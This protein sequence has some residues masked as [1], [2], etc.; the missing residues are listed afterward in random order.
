VVREEVLVGGDDGLPGL[1]RGKDERPRGLVAS[2][3]LDHDVD[4]WIGDD[5]CRSIG[6]E[7]ARQPPVARRV[8]VPNRDRGDHESVAERRQAAHDGRP[9]SACAEQ[10][11]AQRRRLHGASM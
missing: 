5:V 3:Q 4:A 6:Q 2:E 8:D 7:V 9:H 1:K 10:T 11:D